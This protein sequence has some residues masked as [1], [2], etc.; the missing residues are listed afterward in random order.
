LPWGGG[1]VRA[2]C[3]APP[4]TLSRVNGQWPGE[5]LPARLR[6]CRRRSESR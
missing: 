4:G 5:L 1:F 6:G 3:A 2:V